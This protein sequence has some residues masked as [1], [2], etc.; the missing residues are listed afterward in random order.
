MKILSRIFSVLFLFAALLIA[1]SP[2]SAQPLASPPTDE[3]DLPTLAPLLKKV[4][5]GVVN[6]AVQGRIPVEE[7]ELSIKAQI[8]PRRG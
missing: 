5:P 1:G 6:I 7:K 8:A 4:M 3:R 2:V